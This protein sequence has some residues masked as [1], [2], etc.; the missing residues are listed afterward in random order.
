[1][2]I[3]PAKASIKGEIIE[4]L[5]IAKSSIKFSSDFIERVKVVRSFLLGDPQ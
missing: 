4:K 5:K 1:M 3:F 2:V